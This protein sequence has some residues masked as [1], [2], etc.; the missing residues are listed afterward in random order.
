MKIDRVLITPD[1]WIDVLIDT[2]NSAIQGNKPI[3]WTDESG[4]EILVNIKQEMIDMLIQNRDKFIV[5]GMDIFKEF[6][7]LVHKRQAFE[8]LVAVYDAMDNEQLIDQYKEDAIKLAEIARVEQE[9]RDFWVW[10]AKQV[11][12]RIALGAIGALLP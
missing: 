4:N 10:L 2:L 3:E 8:A 9:T 12:M 7:A 5:I 1:N 6:C 11:G